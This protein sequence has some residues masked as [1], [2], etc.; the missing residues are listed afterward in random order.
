MD[1]ATQ[2]S[3]SAP[4]EELQR[5]LRSLVER[6]TRGDLRRM[7][8]KNDGGDIL[9]INNAPVVLNSELKAMIELAGLPSSFLTQE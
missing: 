4:S 3:L 6:L 8:M 5:Q 9:S 1:R 7:G 2:T